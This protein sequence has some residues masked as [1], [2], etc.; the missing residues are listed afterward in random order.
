[1]VLGGNEKVCAGRGR[2]EGGINCKNIDIDKKG[3]GELK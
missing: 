2:G 3:Q 1:M